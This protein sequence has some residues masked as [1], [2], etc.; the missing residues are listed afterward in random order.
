MTMDGEPIELWRRGPAQPAPGD[1][2]PA[3]RPDGEV[4][5]IVDRR[6]GRVRLRHLYQRQPLRVLTPTPAAGEPLTLVLGNLSGG[7]VGGDRYRTAIVAEEDADLL[8]CGQAA[9][10]VYRSSGPDTDAAID[11][12]LEAVATM[13]W[14]PQGTILF[15][16]ARL[17]R[18]T[19]VDLA[20]GARLLAGEILVF[21]RLGM[22]EVMRRGRLHDAWRLRVAG[23]LVWADA[24]AL[25]GDVGDT[26]DHPAG[27]HGA[28]ALATVVY[29]AP[30]AADFLQPARDVLGRCAGG[31][32]RA[33]ATAWPRL[34]LLRILGA[35][36]AA[37]RRAV[38]RCWSWLRATVLGRPA[39]LPVLWQ[40]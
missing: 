29:A 26:L 39:A 17:H 3:S 25:D 13:E 34:L 7:M 27:L 18:R 4:E 32:V 30:D 10:K 21:G 37:V 5:A 6:D 12:S 23:R 35:D 1:R 14:L 19:T 24:L 36:P 33:A 28:R 16:G 15:D 31:G 40:I 38:G 8:V 2:P 11:L 20:A 22:G 9:E